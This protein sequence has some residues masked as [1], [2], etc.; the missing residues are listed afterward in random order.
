M[1]PQRPLRRLARVQLG[2]LRSIERG[3]SD[4]AVLRHAVQ[5]DHL[6]AD[7]LRLPPRLHVAGEREA[8]VRRAGVVR[9]GGLHVLAGQADLRAAQPLGPEEDLHGDD[10]LDRDRP[11]AQRQPAARVELRA[12]DL[13]NHGRQ[14][15]IVCEVGRG[16]LRDRDL[17]RSEVLG[18]RDLEPQRL[19]P[20]RLSVRRDHGGQF[21]AVG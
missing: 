14:L 5:R 4:D 6:H 15:G 7:L 12:L 9:E 3:Q 17:R 1:Q 13:Q 2:G 16:A 8:R 11:A 20:R 19:Q 21:E 18:R 10:R